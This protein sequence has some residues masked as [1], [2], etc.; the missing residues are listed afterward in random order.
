MSPGSARGGAHD[1]S[2][3]GC[4]ASVGAAGVGGFVAVVG[5]ENS[6]G[7][8]SPMPASV[9][10]G[11]R[12]GGRSGAPNRARAVGGA[13]VGGGSIAFAGA[14]PPWTNPATAGSGVGGRA[15]AAE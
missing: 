4:D 6:G 1:G 11:G 9:A 13:D 2:R 7:P 5:G 15:A 3:R 10:I 8:S 12:I 14:A